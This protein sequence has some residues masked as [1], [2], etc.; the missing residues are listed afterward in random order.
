MINVYDENGNKFEVSRDHYRNNILPN[1]FANSWN[2]AQKLYDAIVIALQDEFVEEVLAPAER[3]FEIDSIRERGYTMFGIALLQNEEY[4]KAEEILEEYVGSFGKS[5][6]VLTNLAKAYSYQGDEVCAK[7]VLWEAVTLDPNLDNAVQWLAGVARDEGGEKAYIETLEKVS[8]IEGSWYAD[9][10]LARNDLE[11]GNQAS[12]ISRYKG[13]LEKAPGAG[14]ALFMMSGDLGRQG[15][16]EDIVELVYPVYKA[17]RHGVGAGMNLLQACLE[18][19]QVEKG[20]E[21]LS[22]IKD[23]E[24]PDLHDHIKHFENAFYG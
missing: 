3:L 6:V 12:A 5:G 9:L 21:V 1:M 22:S 15:R 19:N 2:D 23:L 14:S 17:E 4:K 8:E 13:V 10:W 18:A 16:V 7:E 20:K 24:R 11:I